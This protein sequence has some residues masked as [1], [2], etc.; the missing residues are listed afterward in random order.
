MKPF[1]PKHKSNRAM[2]VLALLFGAFIL[3]GSA[4]ALE[5]A[6]EKQNAQNPAGKAPYSPYVG[7]TCATDVYWGD[8]HLHTAYSFDAGLLGNYRLG[9]EEAYRFA[10]GEEVV[11][12]SGMPVQL[13]RPLDF[14]VVSDHAENL[15]MFPKLLKIDP[16][17]LASDER[18]VALSN[19]L[20]AGPPKAPGPIFKAIK[21]MM[22]GERTKD[23]P[24]R[25]QSEW[26][27]N[28]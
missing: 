23:N 13:S 19:M 15:G 11:S 10:K 17:I 9:P 28:T 20:K 26:N 14:L 3:S 1:A 22:R 7:R 24:I 21:G 16:Q 27:Y 8:T 25:L 2:L 12:N 5:P 4:H 18:G 6:S